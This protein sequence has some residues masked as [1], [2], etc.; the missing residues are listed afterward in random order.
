MELYGKILSPNAKSKGG[1]GKVGRGQRIPWP[2][3]VM[4][5]KLTPLPSN[6]LEDPEKLILKWTIWKVEGVGSV[7]ILYFEDG[8]A[9]VEHEEENGEVCISLGKRRVPE[10]EFTGVGQTHSHRNKSNRWGWMISV[11]FEYPEIDI[12]A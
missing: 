9:V 2:I 8:A 3:W 4:R 7:S 6:M 11:K 5:N 12:R 1:K 10:V